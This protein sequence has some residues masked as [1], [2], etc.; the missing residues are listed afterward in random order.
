VT[1]IAQSLDTAW[2]YHQAGDVRQAESEYRK[3]LAAQP[4]H[5]DA[6]H[7]LGVALHQSGRNAE[8]ID[9][10]TRAIELDRSNATFHNHLGVVHGAAGHALEAEQSFRAA[11]AINPR[12][13]QVHFNL[14]ALLGK[15][16]NTAAAVEHYREALRLRPDFAQ[17]HYNLGNLLQGQDQLA[18]A[19]DHYRRAVQANPRYLRAWSNLGSLAHRQR[20]FD[21]AAACFRRVL[22]LDAQH[23]EAQYGLSSVLQSQGRHEELLEHLLRIVELKPDHPENRNNLGCALL[24]LGRLDEAIESFRR[25]VAARPDFAEAHGNLGSALSVQGSHAEALASFDRA[26]ELRPEFAEARLSRAL[27]WLSQ[28]DLARGWPEYE[29][30]LKFP[31]Q[32]VPHFSQPRWDGSRLDGRTILLHTEQGLGDTVQFIRYVPLVQRL[33]ARVLVGVP[34]AIVPLL[35]QS[36]IEN[37]FSVGAELPRFD[38]H[39]PLPSL[40]GILGTRLDSIPADVP[41]L[42]ADPSLVERWRP[43]VERFAGFKVGITWQGS[44]THVFDRFRSIPLAEFAPIAKVTGVSLVSLQ[45]IHGTEQIGQLSGRFDVADLADDPS[46]PAAALMDTAAI[47]SNLDLVMTCDTATAH[48]AGALGIPVWVALPSTPDW[49]WL[50]GRDDSPWYPTMRLFRQSRLGHWQDV[51]ERIAAELQSM[52]AVNV[53]P[54]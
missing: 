51:F 34:P 39:A 23:V 15:Q 7:L 8:A 38:V 47:I 17:A 41:Y 2:K 46:T 53:Q 40:P 9:E 20:Q 50:I 16:Q 32:T 3:I 4:N 45:R 1:D 27:I 52:L 29:W 11:L 30:R 10:I 26:I 36:G 54:R 25:A 21:E 48:L 13:A 33:G 24:A 28:G 12:D 49:R 14:A 42:R 6:R 22:D 5:A 31:N 18:Q 43:V 35:R 19:A 44:P 37:L